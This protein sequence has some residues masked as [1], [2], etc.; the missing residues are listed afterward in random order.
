MAHLHSIFKQS[1]QRQQT[2]VAPFPLRELCRAIKFSELDTEWN[3]L[4]WEAKNIVSI[5]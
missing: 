1:S 4:V 5:K 3:D 2:N